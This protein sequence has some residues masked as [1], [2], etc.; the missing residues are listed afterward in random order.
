MKCRIFAAAFLAFL[1][2]APAPSATDTNAPRP[3]QLADILAWKRIQ[4]PVVSG[5]GEWFAYRLAAAEGNAEI[6]VRN[7]KT[8]A[9]KR[10]P[11]GDR[12]ASIP[13]PTGGPPTPPVPGAILAGGGGPVLSEDSKW[14]AFSAY[15]LTREAKRLK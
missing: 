11:A 15:P 5:N 10:Y 8:G 13:A 14:L 4:S 2:L 9:E 1:A 3:L 12:T 6:V 7:L